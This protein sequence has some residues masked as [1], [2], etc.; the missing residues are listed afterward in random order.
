MKCNLTVYFQQKRPEYITVF[1]IC[2]SLFFF[3]LSPVF[4]GDINLSGSGWKAWLDENARWEDLAVTVLELE[5]LEVVIQIRR[6][7]RRIP[8]SPC[9]FCAR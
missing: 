8:Q 1:L 6:R 9:P 4:S 3:G 7:R 5:P 2:M